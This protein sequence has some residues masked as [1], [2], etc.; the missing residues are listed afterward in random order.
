MGMGPGEREGMEDE[1]TNFALY[2]LGKSHLS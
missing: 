1:A 2:A